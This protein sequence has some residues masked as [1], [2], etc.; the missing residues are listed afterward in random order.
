MSTKGRVDD[1]AGLTEIFSLSPHEEKGNSVAPIL[2]TLNGS[3][4]VL[5]K[6]PIDSIQC[7][8]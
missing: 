7:L 3:W 5:R 4:M 6:V 2:K 1:Y 8:P